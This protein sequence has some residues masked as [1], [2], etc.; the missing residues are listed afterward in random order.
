MDW[1]NATFLVLDFETWSPEDL[2]KRGVHNYMRHPKTKALC[3]SYQKVRVAPNGS[4]PAV[5][6]GN[7]DLFL[8]KPH[9][10]KQEWEKLFSLVNSS[11]LVAHNLEFEWLMLRRMA[12]E[13]GYYFKPLGLVDTAALSQ[14]LGLGRSLR[15]AGA[16]VGASKL[17][18]DGSL[19]AT[20]STGPEMTPDELINH[21]RYGDLLDYCAQDVEVTTQLLSRFDVDLMQRES[22]RLEAALLMNDTGWPVDMDSVRSMKAMADINKEEAFQAFL[23]DYPDTPE[24]FFGSAKQLRQFTRDRGIVMDSF[25]EQH[26]TAMVRKLEAQRLTSENE[27]QVLDM[28]YIKQLLGGSGL[29]KLDVIERMIGDDDRLRGQYM[30]IGAGQSYRTTGVGVQMQNLK[31]LPPQFADL[32]HALKIWEKEGR[33]DYRW[34]NDNLGKNLRQVFNVKEPGRLIVGD[35]SSVE[36]RALAWVAGAEWKLAEFR[37]GKDMYKV[38]AARIFHTPYEDVVKAQRQIGKVGELSCGYNAG[39]PA[40]QDYGAKM[41]IELSAVE[42]ADL[43][44]NWRRVNVEIVA[45]W[46]ELDDALRRA[47]SR[48]GTSQSVEL[49]HGSITVISSTTLPSINKQHPGAEDLTVF[50]DMDGLQPFS[51]VLR[52]VYKMG[53]SLV[54]HKP[55]PTKT[56]PL[57]RD[58]Y[59]SA[60]TKRRVKNTIYGGKLTGIVIQSLCRELFMDIMVAASEWTQSLSSYTGVKLVGQF[61]DELV[62]EYTPTTL[63]IGVVEVAQGLEIL[64]STCSLPGFPLEAEVAMDRRYIK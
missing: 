57:W 42:A 29:S 14:A 63:G 50:I 11:V 19:I 13:L 45:L 15:Q 55:S 49:P 10:D 53:T 2:L 35:F 16:M 43:V 44:R 30:H 39:G 24:T 22:D 33:P 17:D 58:Y 47:V 25:D 26:V 12:R 5:R 31:R 52:G 60:K 62:L 9:V 20:F 64:M 48:P 56:G 8:Q 7:G 4:K 46:A 38:M 32:P 23:R 40:V 37:R 27:E 54:Y 1:S 28:L 34:T 18:E 41:G 6:Y 59:V 21:P 3:A 61:H 36:S 51:R